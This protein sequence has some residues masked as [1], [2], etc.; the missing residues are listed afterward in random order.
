MQHT[1]TAVEAEM[2]DEDTFFADLAA[3][4]R[5]H[6]PAALD[7]IDLDEPAG[8]F[9]ASLLADYPAGGDEAAA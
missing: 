3:Q 2:L 1:L 6:G 8:E 5:L 9:I 4:V 7:G